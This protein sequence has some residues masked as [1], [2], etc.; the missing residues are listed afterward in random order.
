MS[1]NLQD[2]LESLPFLNADDLNRTHRAVHGLLFGR[3]PSDPSD[4][5]A[6]IAAIDGL[7]AMVESQ[8]QWYMSITG[9]C[10]GARGRRP[11]SETPGLA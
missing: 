6:A 8:G 9:T 3:P 11:L 7:A 1:S 4:V 10:P 5:D 2:V